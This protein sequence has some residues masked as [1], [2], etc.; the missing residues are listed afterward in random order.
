[1]EPGT[2]RPFLRAHPR[3][4]HRAPVR[5]RMPD[6]PRRTARRQAGR[7]RH[8]RGDLLTG[9]SGAALRAT[10]TGLPRNDLRCTTGG[11][12]HHTRRSC[13]TAPS[14]D[15]IPEGPQ[16]ISA[17]RGFEA[18]GQ[19][20]NGRR[21]T[22]EGRRKR[23]EGRSSSPNIGIAGR[24]RPANGDPL[25]SPVSRFPFPLSPLPSPVSR[26]SQIRIPPIHRRVAHFL[27]RS[28]RHP[29]IQVEDAAGLVVGTRRAA[30]TERLL[31]HHC[32]GALVVDV[33]VA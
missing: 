18:R 20:E 30:T 1:R 32:A 12:A 11:P 22:G 14:L 3:A 21:E 15:D 23:G 25:P 31:S 8:L 5:A 17:F 16:A 26:L 9:G 10:A 2:P 4:R 13:E 28:R 27:D 29:A 33:V 19:T 7:T 6:A 24:S